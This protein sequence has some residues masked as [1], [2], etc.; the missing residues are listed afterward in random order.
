MVAKIHL[1]T[2]STIRLRIH[3]RHVG[4]KCYRYQIRKCGIISER[5]QD[6]RPTQS[7][8]LR[9][10]PTQVTG[11]KSLTVNRQM[12]KILHNARKWQRIGLV[13]TKHNANEIQQIT[14]K[15]AF[16]LMCF[17]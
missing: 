13:D 1:I 3:T 7:E 4:G 11:K 10:S 8:R 5:N 6:G 17:V 9:F 16:I 12:N 14:Q 2:R 15:Y